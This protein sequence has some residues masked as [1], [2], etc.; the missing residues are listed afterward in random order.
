MFEVYT[1]HFS[2]SLSFS[3]KDG[4]NVKS[5]I[6][7]TQWF[8]S[9]KNER[10]GWNSWT[11]QDLTFTFDIVLSTLTRV[12]L[13]LFNEIRDRLDTLLNNRESTWKLTFSSFRNAMFQNL[14][15]LVFWKKTSMN[16]GEIRIFENFIDMS[17]IISSNFPIKYSVLR[18][19]IHC[20]CNA[21]LQYLK[22]VFKF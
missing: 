11:I 17:M 5:L 10:G 9:L 12:V 7:S 21:L 19:Q 4:A 8:W 6:I 2:C 22:Y 13:L 20:Q 15:V 18:A 3:A 1:S 14:N 16:R